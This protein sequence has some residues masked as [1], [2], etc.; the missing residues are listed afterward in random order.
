M[1]KSMRCLAFFA[2]V[3]VIVTSCDKATSSDPKVVL[4]Q[5]IERMIKKDIDGAAKLAT[6]ESQSMFSMMKM[7]LA[8]A[9]KNKDSKEE[10]EKM[11]EFKDMEIGSATITGETAVVPVKNK[12]KGFELEI[13]LKKEGGGWKVDF[14]MQTMM[15]MAKDARQQ[16]GMDTL[17][18][19]ISA[20]DMEKGLKM[21]DSI[22]KNMDPEKMKEMMK[23]ME[24]MKEQQ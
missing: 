15:K 2:V 5:F 14:T 10:T 18:Q 6:E 23:A 4:T 20:E 8:M 9:E 21:A 7:G 11:D 16:E 24:K 3:S 22:R 19:N 13:P 1:K 12:K 17:R